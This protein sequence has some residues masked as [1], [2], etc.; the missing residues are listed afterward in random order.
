[1]FSVLNAASQTAEMQLF[2]FS[3]YFSRVYEELLLADS[4]ESVRSWSFCAATYFSRSPTVRKVHYDM[5]SL[6][7]D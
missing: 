3:F 2:Y 7:F 4:A 6:S 1:M 5:V